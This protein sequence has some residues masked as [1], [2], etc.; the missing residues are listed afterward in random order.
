MRSVASLWATAMSGQP[1][2][3]LITLGSLD[4]RTVAAKCVR[5][6]IAAIEADQGGED[7][8]TTATRSVAETAAVTTAMVNDLGARWLNGEEIDLALFCTLGNAQRRLFE[9]IGFPASLRT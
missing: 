5:D 6:M 4:R 7:N 1:K 2:V 8:M 3:R 9:T